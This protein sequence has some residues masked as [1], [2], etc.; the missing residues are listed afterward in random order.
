MD[1]ETKSSQT[2]MAET[3]ASPGNPHQKSK[4]QPAEKTEEIMAI[5]KQCK[6]NCEDKYQDEKYG[7]G[8]RVMNELK[9]RTGAGYRCTICKLVQ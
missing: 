1:K 6:G 9:P 3:I 5:V 7:K 8:L 4:R 2:S